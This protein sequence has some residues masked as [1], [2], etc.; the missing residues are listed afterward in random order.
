MKIS[1]NFRKC[2]YLQKHFYDNENSAIFPSTIQ[3][4]KKMKIYLSPT[5]RNS[6]LD[7]DKV[8]RP[9]KWATISTMNRG[10][11]PQLSGLVD[12]KES[13][14]ERAILEW[15]LFLDLDHCKWPHQL[16]QRLSNRS[17]GLA[18]EKNISF[19]CARDSENSIKASKRSPVA[20]S[21]GHLLEKRHQP[22]NLHFECLPSPDRWINTCSSA[23]PRASFP[24]LRVLERRE[25]FHGGSS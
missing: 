1:K 23:V 12:R 20:L 10:R 25:E 8:R 16:E 15:K 14:A 2:N 3:N 6:T 13:E 24:F 21:G 19:V 5:T 4:S 22:P 11:C 18:G 17:I 9:T 7:V